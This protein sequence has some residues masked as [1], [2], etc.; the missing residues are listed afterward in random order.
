MKH[1]CW[2]CFAG[3]MWLRLRHAGGRSPQGTRAVPWSSGW[4]RF[5]EEETQ[6][7][8]GQQFAR[9]LA[10]VS[11]HARG[12]RPAATALGPSGLCCLVW[13]ASQG[14]SFAL[15]LRGRGAPGTLGVWEPVLGVSG[16]WGAVG[17]GGCG[18]LVPSGLAWDPEA[19]MGHGPPPQ[20]RAPLWRP[21][22]AALRSSVDEGREATSPHV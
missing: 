14:E 2:L 15:V 1:H 3:G 7:H 22:L 9:G 4:G 21:G 13:K 19:H 6:A 11:L 10:P 18:R 8:R 17:E 12:P 5:T 16:V 20:V